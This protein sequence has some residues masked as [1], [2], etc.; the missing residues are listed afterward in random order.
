MSSYIEHTCNVLLPE[1]GIRMLTVNQ[2][3]RTR[4]SRSD[5]RITLWQFP[6][7]HRIVQNDVYEV[8]IFVDP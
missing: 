8:G 4:R 7:R 6:L 2:R 3:E 5:P 1:K